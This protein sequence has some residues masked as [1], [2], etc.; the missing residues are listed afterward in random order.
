MGGDRNSPVINSLRGITKKA[1]CANTKDGFI[2]S[3]PTWFILVLL[4]GTHCPAN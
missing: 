3:S 1:K 4:S 2:Q